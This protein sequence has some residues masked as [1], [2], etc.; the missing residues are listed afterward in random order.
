[1]PT[2]VINSRVVLMLRL[3]CH[4]ERIYKQIIFCKTSLSIKVTSIF[5]HKITGLA[6]SL[7]KATINPSTKPAK[8]EPKRFFPSVSFQ[9]HFDQ[10]TSTKL[11]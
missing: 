3:I 4:D 2:W 9:F 7:P 6:Q 5:L 11:S 10:I 1:M 8:V